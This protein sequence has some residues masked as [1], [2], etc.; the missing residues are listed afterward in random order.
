MELGPAAKDVCRL[1]FEAEELEGDG[2]EGGVGDG[3][4]RGTLKVR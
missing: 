2:K 4:V 1:G 3:V